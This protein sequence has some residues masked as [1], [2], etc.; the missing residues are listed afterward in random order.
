[1]WVEKADCHQL[2]APTPQNLF[3]SRLSGG[4]LC[5]PNPGPVRGASAPLCLLPGFRDA[6]LRALL[7][8]GFLLAFLSRYGVGSVAGSLLIVAFTIQWAI[9]AQGLFYFSQNS[10]IYVS[11]Q[12]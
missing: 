1:M 8:F 7:G 9:L 10:K 11:T 12:R 4:G 3:D 2:K 5:H 6:H